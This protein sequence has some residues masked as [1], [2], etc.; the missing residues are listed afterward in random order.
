MNALT[1]ATLAQARA[2]IH[3][4][5]AAYDDTTRRRQCAQSAR[6]NAT[7]VVLAGDAT[8]DELRHAHYYLD[9]ATGILAT[10]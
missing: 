3:A 6:D 1:A 2:D 4:A 9:D 7:T 8:D 10:T 5:V